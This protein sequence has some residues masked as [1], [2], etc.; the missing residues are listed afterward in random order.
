MPDSRLLVISSPYA[1]FGALYQ[2]Y[3]D[4][5]GKDDAP[6]LIWKAPTTTM[7]PNISDE[8]V[9]TEAERDPDAAQRVV[10]GVS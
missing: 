1:K 9:K 8:F 6:A 7:N 3:R 10:R 4:S 2:A 5:Y